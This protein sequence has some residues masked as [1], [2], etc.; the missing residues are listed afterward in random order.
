MLNLTFLP[1]HF[2]QRLNFQE[3]AQA[4]VKWIILAWAVKLFHQVIKGLINRL[5]ISI[6]RK[7]FN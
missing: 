4:N 1:E 6:I 2:H 7:L 3:T 5:L